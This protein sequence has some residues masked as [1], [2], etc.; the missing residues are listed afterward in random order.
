MTEPRDHRI[1]KEELIDL[2]RVISNNAELELLYPDDDALKLGMDSLRSRQKELHQ[3]YAEAFKK[4]NIETYD[5]TLSGTPVHNSSVSVGYLGKILASFQDTITSLVNRQMRG[6][7]A[8]G[9]IPEY[10]RKTAQFNA[11]LTSPGSFRVIMTSTNSTLLASPPYKQALAQ[12]NEM[13][14]CGSD[15][16]K[17]KDLRSKVG[18]RSIARYKE[19]MKTI[20][21]Y[22]GS[23]K[24][25]DEFGGD[26]FKTYSV[27]FTQATG[28]VDAIEAVEKTPDRTVKDTGRFSKIDLDKNQFRFV[29]D[30]NESRVE[31]RFGVEVPEDVVLSIV[32]RTK[33]VAE[34]VVETEYIPATDFESQTW[35][36]V[37][38][39]EKVETDTPNPA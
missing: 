26:S 27:D 25:Y 21:S 15:R 6:E 19:F 5:I 7:Q 36:I 4:R 24:L 33:Y 8:R 29:F 39:L 13:I 10:I 34:F 28:I 9:T 2:N 35:T 32:P 30:R 20:K 23:V 16:D 3:E 18:I 22:N 31:C 11:I 38:I 14:E 37:E 12:F 1:V 17:I